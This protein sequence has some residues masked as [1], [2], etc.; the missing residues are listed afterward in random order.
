ML[1]DLKMH[2]KRPAVIMNEIG[3]VNLDGL[4]VDDDVPV[5]EMLNRCFC[6]T[7]REDLSSTLLN[8][9]R[10]VQPDVIVIESIGIANP[11]EFIEGIT[12]ASIIAGIEL[13]LVTTVISAPHFFALTHREK[14]KTRR[15]LEE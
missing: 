4:L 9:Y 7:I 14:S 10:Q 6:S 13:R 2:G 15:L 1:K 5:I 3:D 8:I 11:L 12:N